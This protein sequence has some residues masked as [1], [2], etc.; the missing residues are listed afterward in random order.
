LSEEL[1]T[2]GSADDAKFMH[3]FQGKTRVELDGFEVTNQCTAYDTQLGF[4]KLHAMVGDNFLFGPNRS[5]GVLT[6]TAYGEVTVAMI[7][8]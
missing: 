5:D 6:I 1:P 3:T 2:F 4:V 8:E 7:D